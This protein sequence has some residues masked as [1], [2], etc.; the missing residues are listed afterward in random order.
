RTRPS[1]LWNVSPRFG[2][3]SVLS[4]QPRR[5]EEQR[6]RRH[7]RARLPP[8]RLRFERESAEEI[9]K[10]HCAFAPLLQFFASSPR[11]FLFRLRGRFRRPARNEVERQTRER[12]AQT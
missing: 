2:R 7:P 3:L 1:R 5:P 9:N 12:D 11:Q 4:S 10:N 8:P 6:S